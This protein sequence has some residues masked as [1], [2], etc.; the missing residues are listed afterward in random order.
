[1]ATTRS[2]YC[3]FSTTKTAVTN[4][5]NDL[6]LAADSGQVSALCLLDL[7][8]VLDTVDHDLHLLHLER[9]SADGLRGVV[10]QW[11]KSYLSDRSSRVIYNNQISS[12]VLPTSGVRS[13]L[14]ILYTADLANEVQQHVR[15]LTSQCLVC[16]SYWLRLP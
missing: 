10:L 12:S 4:I 14:C 15:E 6:L 1:M 7:T 11:F 3:Q 8:V 13:H 9:Q 2:A 5:Y 16:C